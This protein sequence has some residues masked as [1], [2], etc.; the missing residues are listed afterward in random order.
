M[1]KLWHQYCLI[2][3]YCSRLLVTPDTFFILY[4]NFLTVI[5][6]HGLFILN[7]LAFDYLFLQRINSFMSK[8]IYLDYN[9]TTTV[10]TNVLEKM[11]PYFSDK[12]GNAASS[13]HVFGA[14]A[15]DAIEHARQQV[16]Q[17]IHAETQEVIFTS[18]STE[19]INLA[20]KGVFQLYQK[21]GN[22]IVTVSTE[23]KAVLDTCSYLEKKGARITHLGV[24]RNGLIN[25]NELKDAITDKTILVAVMYANN[26]TG[27]IQQISAIG[28]IV[29]QKNSIFLCDA[30][31][32]IG[33]IPV[34]VQ[35][36]N[37]DLLCLSAH[38]CYGPKGIGAL[39]VR[40]KNPRVSLEPLLHG[41]GH[42]RGWRSGTLNVPGIVGLGEACRQIEFND[43]IKLLRDKLE[44]ELKKLFKESITINGFQTN[45]INN[46][47]NIT[48]PFKAVDFIR[49]T[50]LK[51]A[52]ATGSACTSAE[53]LPSHVL[54]AMGLTKTQAERTIRFSLGKY[55][56]RQD[57]DEVINCVADLKNK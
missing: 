21:K 24:D 51:L 40:R 9:A 2:K 6:L 34:N 52:V 13:T 35:S 55:T 26:E 23:H 15:K 54:L 28:E 47:S 39:Y 30:T 48:F 38:K 49:H 53:N 16:A 46:T 36:D 18:G 3:T 12:F 1:G 19:S 33:K 22:H 4:P 31:Q 14:V 45:R 44:D 56:T 43:S 7:V 25:L 29:H 10:D 32:A 42:E 57:I 17:T 37:I 41:G 50:K 20:I 11:L 27:V 8:I 5:Q